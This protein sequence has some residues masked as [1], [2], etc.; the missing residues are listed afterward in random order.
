MVPKMEKEIS[1]DLIIEQRFY[2]NIIGVFRKVKGKR[3][4]I[5]EKYRCKGEKIREIRD[6]FN[7]TNII[8]PLP[9]LKSDKLTI[10]GPKA[11][12]GTYYKYLHHM[13][14]LTIAGEKEAVAKAKA[15]IQNTYEE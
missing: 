1:K 10:R 5:G 15:R 13:N 9:S 2:R 4:K 11:D 6:K 12:V 8:F 14:E 7:Q 3:V